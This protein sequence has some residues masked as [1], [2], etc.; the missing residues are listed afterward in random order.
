MEF[1]Y[2]FIHLFNWGGGGCVCLR[3]LGVDGTGQRTDVR[4]DEGY[5]VKMASNPKL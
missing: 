5:T 4:T 3:G 1:I 2:V